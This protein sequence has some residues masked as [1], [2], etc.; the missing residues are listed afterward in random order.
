MSKKILP[1]ADNELFLPQVTAQFPFSLPPTLHFL[2]LGGRAPADTWLTAMSD[3]KI[4]WAIDKGIDQFYRLNMVPQKLVGDADSG[5]A[6][7]WD[8]ANRNRVIVC[9]H[10]TAKDYTDT[11]LALFALADSTTDKNSQTDTCRPTA[12]PH[13]APAFA[14]LS[15]AFGG[16]LDHLFSTLF[17]AANANTRNC[18]ADEREVVFFVRS[19]EFIK[20]TFLTKPQALSLLPLTAKCTGIN[21][22]GTRWELKTASLH[23]E[24]PFA[25][26]NETVAQTCRITIKTGLLAV[27]LCFP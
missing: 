22:N 5:T 8:W 2:L 14:I 20:L 9:R 3:N 17:S 1:V 10:P 26:S 12:T 4:L 16:R 13:N 19:G 6:K 21:L 27:Y 23:Q 18:L 25:V 15:G 24:L 7:A 11:Q